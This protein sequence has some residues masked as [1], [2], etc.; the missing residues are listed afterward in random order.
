MLALSFTKF[1]RVSSFRGLTRESEGTKMGTGSPKEI[2]S[3]LH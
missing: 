1:G 2:P 3:Y